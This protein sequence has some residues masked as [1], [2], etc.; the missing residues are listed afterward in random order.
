MIIIKF[1]DGTFFSLFIVFF[2]NKGKEKMKIEIVFFYQAPKN[3]ENIKL[4]VI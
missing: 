2:R 4:N 3:R 1:N